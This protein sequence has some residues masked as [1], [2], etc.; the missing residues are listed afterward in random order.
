MEQ[1]VKTFQDLNKFKH[2]Y[3][4]FIRS[5]F[6][7]YKVS[8]L[9]T[10]TLPIVTVKCFSRYIFLNNFKLIFAFDLHNSI[11]RKKTIAMSSNGSYGLNFTA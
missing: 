2:H 8:Q 10:Q 1:W 3:I 5:S 9:H 4:S 6:T 7:V 11:N